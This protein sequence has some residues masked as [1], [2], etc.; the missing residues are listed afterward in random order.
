MEH[1]ADRLRA[2]PQSRL[3]RS[4]A[5]EA[6]A[7][8][9]ELSRRAQLL[10]EPDGEPREMPDAGMFA[11]ADQITVAGNDLAVV[12]ESEEQVAEAV[13]LVEEARKKAGV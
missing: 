3:Q 11:V 1:F 9:R 5:A 10:E 4:A 6:L 12:L 7:A 2:A 13:R 8:A